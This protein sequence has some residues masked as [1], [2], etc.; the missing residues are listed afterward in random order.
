VILLCKSKDALSDRVRSDQDDRED[1]GI[2]S[3][4]EDTDVENHDVF[5]I[6]D[7][8]D[9]LE[10]EMSGDPMDILLGLD[11]FLEQLDV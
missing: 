1:E 11:D 7:L 8:M 2:S 9:E 6:D 5:D 4:L 3:D 10:S